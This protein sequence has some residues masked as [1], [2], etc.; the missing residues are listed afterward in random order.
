MK[1]IHFSH[2][3]KLFN[4]DNIEP[5]ENCKWLNKPNG[6]LWTSP[7]NSKYGWKDWNEYSNYLSVD[8]TIPHVILKLKPNCKILEVNSVKDIDDKFMNKS[9]GKINF[10]V[11][12]KEYDVF[13]LTYK[14]LNKVE[15]GNPEACFYGWDCETVLLLN[16]TCF[17][18]IKN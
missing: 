3:N 10:E 1:V 11:I 2:S 12:S 16:N 18:I 6:G 8:N 15:L 7:V 14:C 5:I 9:S 4:I 13:W 17:N